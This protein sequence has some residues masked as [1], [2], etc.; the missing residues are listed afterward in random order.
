[1]KKDADLLY[2][3]KDLKKFHPTHF[4]WKNKTPSLEFKVHIN[5]DKCIFKIKI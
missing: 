3:K 2:K 4:T 5:D 1:L